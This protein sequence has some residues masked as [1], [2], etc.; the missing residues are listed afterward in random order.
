[1]YVVLH[2]R[3]IMA[4]VSISPYQFAYKGHIMYTT[5]DFELFAN[6]LRD[7]RPMY[8]SGETGSLEW[9]T[10]LDIAN[11]IEDIFAESNP[12]FDKLKFINVRNS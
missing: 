2:G 11:S 12:R 6:M 4:R 10:W 3:F 8:V 1:M 7:N 9:V 5:K